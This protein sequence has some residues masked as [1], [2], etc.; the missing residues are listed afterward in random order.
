[1]L[2]LYLVCIFTLACNLKITHD[3]ITVSKVKVEN[4]VSRARN[5]VKIQQQYL[6]QYY[7]INH[8]HYYYY[9]CHYHLFSPFSHTGTPDMSSMS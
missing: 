8:Y 3:T 2:Y 1:M 4:V 6:G 5:V 9:H 7:Y